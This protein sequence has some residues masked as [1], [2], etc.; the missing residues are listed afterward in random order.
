[1]SLE[2]QTV[3]A[4]DVEARALMQATGEKSEPQSQWNVAER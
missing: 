1:M 2:R 3:D 4:A